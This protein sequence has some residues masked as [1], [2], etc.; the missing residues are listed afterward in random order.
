MSDWKAKR[1][2]KS[3]EAVEV[4]GGYS[5]ELDG[6][7]VKTPAKSA[8]VLPTLEMAQEIACE[9]DA[10]VD[11]IDPTTM[12]VTR[13]A[14]AAIDKVATQQA[15]VAELLAAYGDS[16]LLCYRATSPEALISLQRQAWDPLLDWAA[17]AL[18]ATLISADGV[19][20]VPQN[21]DA[22]STLRRE[23]DALSNFQ[24]AA[25]H[26]LVSM[27]GSLI[28]AFAVIRKHVSVSDAWDISRVDEDYQISQWGEDD[29]ASAL[30]ASKKHAFE[31]AAK[32]FDM[33]VT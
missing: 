26:D 28:I 24:L 7:S 5:V 6:R 22:L 1:F 3:A 15:E 11:Q 32:F 13:S 29:E 12:P 25:F 2:W 10:Q 19:M 33:C 17:T 27:S 8:L 23:V 31:H 20:H 9:W 16:D 30:A 14:N 21:P 4:S 18:G